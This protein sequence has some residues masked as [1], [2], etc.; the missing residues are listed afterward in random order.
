MPREAARD[1][2]KRQPGTVFFGWWVTLASLIGMVFGT[3]AV[4]VFSLGVFI[5]PLQQEFGWT[6]AQISGA[7][8]I[9]VWVS[10]LTQPIQGILTDRY[11]V[12]RVVLPSIPIFT[13]P[14]ALLYFLASNIFV[15]TRLGS[16]SRCAG[17]RCGT[18]PTTR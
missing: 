2:G 15:F 4:L 18:A 5:Q 13:A 1:D 8:A 10:V 6:R 7:A 16:S 17:S 14:L 3:A 11:G 9:I 12:R